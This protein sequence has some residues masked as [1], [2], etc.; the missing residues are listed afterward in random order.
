MPNSSRFIEEYD[1]TPITV[2]RETSRPD[3]VIDMTFI[4]IMPHCFMKIEENAK[5]KGISFNEEVNMI[6]TKYLK[7]E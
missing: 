5:K 7:G 2:S 1:D 3:D 6:F 4:G